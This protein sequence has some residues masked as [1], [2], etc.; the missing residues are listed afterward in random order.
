VVSARFTCSMIRPAAFRFVAFAL[1][2]AAA[3][4]TAFAQSSACQR[5][6]AELG[7]LDRG[8]GGS[9]Y[10]AA[11]QRQRSEIGRLSAYYQSLGCDRGRFLF[12]GSPPPAECGGIAQRIQMMQAN[13]H[14]LAARADPHD[15]QARRQQLLAAIEHACDPRQLAAPSDPLAEE[16]RRQAA[17]RRARFRSLEDD[18]D[19]R[20][21]GGGKIVCVRS[22]DGF[23][24]PLHNLPD[25]R[26][27]ANQMCKALCPGAETAA[28]SMPSGE[29]DIEHAVS[30]TTRRPYTRLGTAF[31]YQ[32]SFD[33]SC[34]CKKDGQT[35]A[36]ALQKAERMLDHHRGDIIVTAKKAEELSR[37]KS[38]RT[39][40]KSRKKE[41]PRETFASNR[42]EA[43]P[44]VAAEAAVQKAAASPGRDVET[45]G[46][47]NVPT[48]SKAS[49]GIGP[50]TIDAPEPLSQN[51]GPTVDVKDDA[52]GQRKVRIVAPDLI[53]VPRTETP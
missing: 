37:P 40:G 43:S 19:R 49:S 33:A 27:G 36:Q 2:L 52:S 46:S 21:T 34:S 38:I 35:W 18:D 10:E 45:T 8:G 23:F 29:G 26:A 5:Y 13:V 39:A 11:A 50:Q 47:V 7:A 22:C 12:F 20:A 25:G 30:L 42:T 24:F 28:Y 17:E 6:R 16:R 4:G 14:Q 1:A 15:R 44:A 48:A 51:A 31:K 3:S 9:G 32:K 53:P 41:A